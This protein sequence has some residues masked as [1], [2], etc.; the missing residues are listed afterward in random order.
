MKLV[1]PHAHEISKILAGPFSRWG[2]TQFLYLVWGL[3]IT[4]RPLVHFWIT[5]IMCS[6]PYCMVSFL[7]WGANFIKYVQRNPEVSSIKSF[8]GIQLQQILVIGGLPA[9]Q[10][11]LSLWSIS[12]LSVSAKGASSACFWWPAP[13][14]WISSFA[15]QH[16]LHFARK[17][18]KMLRNLVT[19]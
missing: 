9:I 12:L 2:A 7:Q 5:L 18:P 8:V 4:H 13:W 17:L 1:R 15:R 3:K 11:C 10:G 16:L 19:S 14:V 6:A